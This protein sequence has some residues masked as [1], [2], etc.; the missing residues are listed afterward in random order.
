MSA[1]ERKIAEI[2]KANEPV[3]SG[4]PWWLADGTPKKE[5]PK[6][7]APPLIV[8]EP[9][10]VAVVSHFAEGQVAVAETPEVVFHPSVLPASVQMVAAQPAEPQIAAQ[11]SQHELVPHSD[12]ASQPDQQTLAPA[13]VVARVSGLREKFLWLGR[14][15]RFMPHE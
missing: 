12:A 14:K 3:F 15:K 5:P 2:A 7:E 9:Q 8:P 13:E 4:D 10:P 6:P 11:I 1:R